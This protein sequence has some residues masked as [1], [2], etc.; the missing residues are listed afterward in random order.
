MKIAF[1]FGNGRSRIPYNIDILR[2][3]GTIIGCNNAY[4]D[5]DPDILVAVDLPMIQTILESKQYKDFYIPKNMYDEHFF[6]DTRMKYYDH[7]CPGIVDSGNFALMIA[8]I[9]DHDII[10]MLGFDYVS[11]NEFT[12]NVYAGHHNYKQ[13]H[14]KHVLSESEM[15]WYNKLA[16]VIARYPNAFIRVNTNK[17]VPP[18]SWIRFKNIEIQEFL[19]K[20]PYSYDTDM[21]IGPGF[22]EEE[23]IALK[24][25][26]P[27]DHFDRMNSAPTIYA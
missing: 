25:K 1:V 26:K 22:T 3:H 21:E 14:Q 24:S 4:L 11:M 15:N 2:K 23:Y 20:F 10:Y 9:T 12:N 19:D 16:I 8:S 18:T 6:C 27:S 5:V 13:K 17:Y 7:Q